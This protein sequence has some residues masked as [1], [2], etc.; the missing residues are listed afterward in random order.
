MQLVVNA[1]RIISAIQFAVLLFV[2]TNSFWLILRCCIL[3]MWSSFAVTIFLVHL[4]LNWFSLLPGKVFEDVGLFDFSFVVILVLL[5]NSELV[6]WR[7][8]IAVHLLSY[9]LEKQLKSKIK[10]WNS[11]SSFSKLE[12]LAKT[13]VCFVSS[14][15]Q[16]VYYWTLAD[17][18]GTLSDKEQ[19]YRRMAVIASVSV[20]VDSS[21]LIGTI[22][23][24]L[25]GLQLCERIRLRYF[26]STESFVNSL[27]DPQSTKYRLLPGAAAQVCRLTC[28]CMYSLF[29]P[30]WL[31]NAIVIKE[32]ISLW[33]SCDSWK[34][35]RHALDSIP[36]AKAEAA[37]TCCICLE[38]IAVGQAAR[39]LDCGHFFHSFCLRGWISSH[40]QCPVCR[41]GVSSLG[42]AQSLPHS[43]LRRIVE[44]SQEVLPPAEAPRSSLRSL[45]ALRE[46]RRTLAQADDEG[47]SSMLETPA[48][49]HLLHEAN[50]ELTEFSSQL[51]RI[52]QHLGSQERTS[53]RPVRLSRPWVG[54]PRRESEGVVNSPFSF[55]RVGIPSS[56]S[57]TA[58]AAP[59]ENEASFPER[60]MLWESTTF[61]DVSLLPAPPQEAF[62]AKSRTSRVKKRPR[63]VS[64]SENDH[65]EWRE[66]RKK[67]KGIKKK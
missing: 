24:S 25:G 15:L 53:T 40:S 41:R 8:A 65:S 7:V 6:E 1:S 9:L 33:I 46:L 43:A 29:H 38:H 5:S 23:L 10:Y 56:S 35:Y 50:R 2:A 22:L 21:I 44:E 13:L 58:S 51:Q 45:G 12:M 16:N 4:L 34:A 59:R 62:T 61:E 28:A 37:T 19:S 36:L 20:V 52:Q 11:M 63:A 17:Q 39:R 18:N 27:F 55:V 66:P 64:S 32:A 67:S 57:S 31:L 60:S 47:G 3:L 30:D 42:S 49:M 14:V 54:A 26:P 48:S